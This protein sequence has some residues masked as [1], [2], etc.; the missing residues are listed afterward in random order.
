MGYHSSVYI[1]GFD[2]VRYLER[3]QIRKKENDLILV[4]VAIEPFPMTPGTLHIMPLPQYELLMGTLPDAV[5]L[6]VN[7]F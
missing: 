3:L 4:R 1:Q 2:A 5:V 7:P 6:C